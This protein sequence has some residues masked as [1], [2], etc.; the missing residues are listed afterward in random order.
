MQ[1]TLL[2]INRYYHSFNNQD[3]ENFLDCL[4][5]D[6]AHDI[7]QGTTEVGKDAFTEFMEHMNRCY[8][9]LVKDLVIMTN[10]DGSRASAEFI[11]EGTYLVTDKGLPPASGQTYELPVGAFFEI[12]NNKITRIT[13]YY[14]LNEWLRQVRGTDGK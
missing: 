12:K 13:N 7:N 9:E 1:E 2:L 8:R 3:L 5:E 6:V 4:S 11:V 14:N 10:D